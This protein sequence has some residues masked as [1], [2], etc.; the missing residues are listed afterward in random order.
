[1]MDNKVYFSV[2]IPVYKVEQY[3][4]ECITSVLDQTFT[5]W[6]MI[7]VDDGSPD[8]CPTI[9]DEYAI[10]ERRITIIHQVN[11]GL[12]E[13]RNCGMKKATGEYILFLDSDD[14]WIDRDFLEQIHNCLSMKNWDLVF[15]KRR[16]RFEKTGELMAE[17]APY[18]YQCTETNTASELLY[19]LSKQDLLEENAS[20]KAIKRSLLIDNA[21]WFKSGIFSE[22]VEWFF[23][24]AMCCNTAGAINIPAYCYR[25]R[26]GSITHTKTEKNV[27]DLLFGIE[28][29]AKCIS[30]SGKDNLIKAALLNRLCYEYCIVVGLARAFSFGRERRE[31]LKKC[32]EYKWLTVWAISRK[33]KIASA[34]IRLFGIKLASIPIGIYVKKR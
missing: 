33:T 25:V 1:M 13:A 32:E 28:S 26:E 18:D 27:R 11:A 19:I 23:R 3:L 10:N 20:V 9:C 24:L 14:Y 2:I 5:N 6:E 30:E 7:L 8:Y 21:L 22:D 12:S 16:K 15:F 34:L 31:I 17:P 29:N 4:Q